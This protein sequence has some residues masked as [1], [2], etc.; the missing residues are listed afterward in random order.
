MRDNNP[1][2]HPT[3][4]PAALLIQAPGTIGFQGDD[5]SPSG[6]KPPFR[7]FER[8][9]FSHIGILTILCL[10]SYPAFYALTFVAKDRSLFIVRLINRLHLVFGDRLRPWLYSSHDRSEFTWVWYRDPLRLHFKQRGP[11]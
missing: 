10:I 1:S 3:E 8:Q 7:T 11:Q 2:P 9:R 6:S 5:K 4:N